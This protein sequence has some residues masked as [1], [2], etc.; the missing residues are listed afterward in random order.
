MFPEQTGGVGGSYSWEG[1]DGLG[2][3]KTITANPKTSIVQELQFD[4]F[5]PSKINWT[6]EPTPD[7]KTKVTWKMNSDK[8]PFMFK[9]FAAVSGGFDNMKARNTLFTGWRESLRYYVPAKDTITPIFIDG[10]LTADHIKI[11]CVT[12]KTLL[13]YEENHLFS[14]SEAMETSCTFKQTTYLAAMIGSLIVN[15][16]LNHVQGSYMPEGAFTVP[17]ETDYYA[18]LML[19]QNA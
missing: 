17:F 5:H 1:K 13:E 14:D 12:P 15:C 16:F 10:R 8:L 6:F 2:N 19:F 11:F 3:M 18:P 9:G 4:D 7:N